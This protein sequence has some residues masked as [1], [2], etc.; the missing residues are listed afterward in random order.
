[1]VYLIL[2]SSD[3]FA[4]KTISQYLLFSIEKQRNLKKYIKYTKKII[5]KYQCFMFYIILVSPDNLIFGKNDMRSGIKS[6][7]WEK[8]LL[9][10]KS[11]ISP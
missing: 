8:F 9:L 3:N 10:K 2:A 6:C 11:L 1:M 7:H 5:K 4:F